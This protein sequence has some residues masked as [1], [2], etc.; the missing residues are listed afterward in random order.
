MRRRLAV[1][2]VL[3]LALALAGAAGASGPVITYTI[4]AGT[5]G[6][7]GWW[8]SAVTV[9]FA[10]SGDAISTTCPIVNTFSSSESSW[11]CSATDSQG[12]VSTLVLPFKIDTT[13]PTVSSAAPDRPPDG[14]GWYSHPVTVAFSGSDTN[15]GLAGCTSAT[16]SGPDS[17]SA[18]VQGTCRD[19][20]GNVSAAAAFALRYDAT[21]PAV[22]ASLSRAAD[23]N[24][25]FSHPVDVSFT[26]T[27]GGSGVSSCTA[28]VSYGGPD[29]ANVSVSGGCVDAA[30]NRATATATFQYDST[31]PAL[32]SVAA[33]V[34][35][36]SAKLTWKAS[37][38]T[39]SLSI[40]RTPGRGHKKSSVVFAGGAA[41][42][43]DTKLE[44]GMTYR[45]EVAAS[46][47]AGNTRAVRVLAIV[48]RLYLPAA[49]ARVGPGAVL[50]WAPVRGASYYNVQIY[51]GARKVLSTW[52]RHPWLRL[53]RTW[54]YA[55]KDQRLAP[56]R[57]RWYVWPGRGSIKAARY[58]AL[59]GGNTFVVR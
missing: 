18:S 46:D 16:Y 45:Y 22:T 9:R 39:A 21:A 38:D 41:S 15:S 27:D 13:P 3:L 25:W 53:R 37:A 48:P 20:A 23:H 10:V 54:S 40:T 50:A 36:L 44:P 5:Q 59:I 7:N 42:F 2:P 35:S 43:R 6:D 14:G 26:G 11:S 31:P 12:A 51:R 49:G 34:V 55:G 29:S 47:A 28:P 52:P 17:G 4:T 33:A 24:G 56:G 30:G 57:Y 8:R 32:T 58:G 1:L 19:V